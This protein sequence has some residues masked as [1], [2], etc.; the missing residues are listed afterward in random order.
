M[1]VLTPVRI[2]IEGSWI[3]N[4]PSRVIRHDS[5]IIAYLV[6]LRP[7]FE[8]RKRSTYRDVRRPRHAAIGAVRIEQLRIEVIRSIP[9]VQPYRIN[10][11]IGSYSQ[12]AKPV[13]F[14]MINGIVVYPVR[15]AKS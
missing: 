9:R 14:V 12:G 6:L 3:G 2:E 4:I 13:P 8:R 5:D 10:P 1:F 7:A 15:R 11:S